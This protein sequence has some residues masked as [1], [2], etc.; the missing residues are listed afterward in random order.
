MKTEIKIRIILWLALGL[1]IVWLLLH[2]IVPGGEIVYIQDFK[3][4]NYFIPKLTPAERIETGDSSVR[5]IGDP[6]YF[7]L[8]APRTFNKANLEIKFRSSDNIRILEAGPLVD[9]IVWRYNL[10]PLMNKTLD[11]LGLAWERQ[12]DNGIV[13][14]QRDKN[15][16]SLENFLTSLP[17]LDEIAIYNYEW[18]Q[19]HLLPDYSSSSDEIIIDI[20]LRGGYQFYIYIKDEKLDLRFI[21]ADL[22]QNKDLDDLEL[23]LYYQ[24]EIIL[25]KS[26]KEASKNENKKI[27]ELGEIELSQSNLPEGVYKIELR[28]GDDI[29]TR[30]IKTKQ[31]KIAFINKIR[32][33]RD[34]KENI[35]IYTDSQQMQAVTPHPDRLQSIKAGSKVLDLSDT[36]KLFSLDI[37]P[38]SATNTKDKSIE[39]TLNLDG[40]TISGDGVFAFARE[41]MINPRLKKV[42]ENIDINAEGINY[43]LANY[44]SPGK[45]NNWQIASAQ[46]DLRQAYCEKGA[47]Q[48]IISVPGIQEGEYVEIDEIRVELTGKGLGKKIMEIFQ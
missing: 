15:Y 9:K 6:V 7:S 29:V 17:A 45:N 3:D 27:V 35:K 23:I 20:P 47:Y 48:F 30:R 42:D 39:L 41:Q 26:V 37:L 11:Q 16:N 10:Q 19:E 25:N 43:V 33:L 5:I 32:L 2:A 44:E 34:K 46:A 8:R 4:S 21:L 22:N 14:L 36:Y 38:T 18:N 1:V 40:V 28:A 31:N 13:F 24:D 12:E